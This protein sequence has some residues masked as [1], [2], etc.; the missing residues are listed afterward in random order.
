MASTRTLPA[1]RNPLMMEDIPEYSELISRRRLGQTKL[2]PKMAGNDDGDATA[3]GV[4]DYAHLRAPMHKGIVSGIFKSSPNSYFLMRRSFDGYVSAT[5][6]F[7]ATFPYAEAA[8][9]EAER[10]YI[11]SLPTTSPEETAGNIWIPPEQALALAEEYQI[12]VWIRAL[13][14]PA[15]I[16]ISQ[17]NDPSSSPA[18]KISAPPKFDLAKATQPLLSPAA[19][20][21]GSASR[22]S[23]R[24]VSPAKTSVR[25]A[26]ASP[27]KR[28]SKAAKAAAEKEAAAAINGDSESTVPKAIGF[29]PTVVLQPVKADDDTAKLHVVVEEPVKGAKGSDKKQTVTEVEVPLPTAGQPPSAE[30]I[31]AMMATAKEQVESAKEADKAAAAK[32]GDKTESKKGKRKA[33][34]ITPAEEGADN[35]DAAESKE[36]KESQPRAKKAKT[37]AEVRKDRVR[38]RAFIGIGATVAVGA[39]VPWLVNF[40]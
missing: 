9:E 21:T 26:P 10:K 5:G 35:K 34:D 15:K 6:M 18:R 33:S 3:L 32:S 14:D 8:D 25:K 31:A 23:R 37:D 36:S 28:S 24:S 30:E 20:T 29:E 16:T 1:K 4:F 40:L 27:R 13:L 19:S 22:R 2:T 39:L 38:N 12:A 11:K 7:K 17:G